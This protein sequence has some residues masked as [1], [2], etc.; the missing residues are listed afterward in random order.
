M[1]TAWLRIASLRFGARGVP[2]RRW[3]VRPRHWARL[4]VVVALG[5]LVLAL[6][7]GVAMIGV[8]LLM[9]T[10]NGDPRTDLV[11]G[12]ENLR[13]V[14][15]K[16][17][18]GGQPDGAGYRRLAE[19]GVTTV[20]DLRTGADDDRTDDDE[21]LLRH[22]GITYHRVP[23]PDGHAPNIA[24]LRRFRTIAR[25]SE[26]IVFVH[27][28]SGVGRTLAL[29]A[30]YTALEGSDP[31]AARLLGVGPVTVAQAWFIVDADPDSVQSVN[32]VVR[33][34]S[35]ALDAPRRAFSRVRA[36]L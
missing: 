24:Q 20:V 9:R 34:I 17:W 32:P 23:I 35:E 16:V 7:V 19:L 2:T 13:F 28:G 26:G 11:A 5:Y 21:H 4:A 25:A 29:E 15:D 27:C 33:R 18:A 6:T 3:I 36:M 1:A 30:G 31:S 8:V 14:D 22:L 12:V 10:L